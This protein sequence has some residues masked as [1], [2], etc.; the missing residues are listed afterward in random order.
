M[1]T[2]ILNADDLGYDPAVSRG[3]V[4]AMRFGLVSSTTFIVNS[5]H[6]EE[7]ARE[8]D[9]LA[10]GLHL[11]LVRFA[12]VSTAVEF[13]EAN[14]GHLGA[15]FV[16]REVHAQLERL[17]AL[18]G[19]EA[20]HIDV[21]KHAHLQG[22]VLEGLARAAKARGLAVRSISSGMRDALRERGV[23]TNDAFLGDAG[24]EAFWTQAQWRR[25]LDLVPPDG[26]V[27]LMCH[28]GYRPS[29]VASGYGAQ[30]E[31]ELATFVSAE[32]RAALEARGLTLS[33]WSGV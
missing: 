14:V 16:E 1:R 13:N 4:E 25:Q 27:E 29:V 6:S 23:R 28:P 15:D 17:S 7:A 9:G 32:A 2:L 22:T 33:S 20:T 18:L 8:A 26:V 3:I 30:R 24:T 21:H 19:R 12:A 11:N 31:V 5:P 10:V